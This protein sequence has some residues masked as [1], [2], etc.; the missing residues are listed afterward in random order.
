MIGRLLWAV[1]SRLLEVPSIDP[2]MLD[3]VEA[4]IREEILA[5][6]A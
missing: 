6:Q 3:A 2:A 4:A 5:D 1:V